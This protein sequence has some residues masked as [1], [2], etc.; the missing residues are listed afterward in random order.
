VAT[1][2][3]TDRPAT[4]ASPIPPAV[5]AID[6]IPSDV[7]SRLGLGPSLEWLLS[8]C[9]YLPLAALGFM[10]VWL[11]WSSELNGC[12]CW[13]QLLLEWFVNWLPAS[14]AHGHNVLV[15]NYQYA[16]GGINLMWNN[17]VLAL[18]AVA[19][20]LT[21]TIGVVHTFA[22]LLTVSLALSASTMFLLLRQW[23][24]WVPAA[25]FGGLVYGFSTLAIVETGSGRL[26]ASFNAIPPLVALIVIKLIRKEWS[27]T[28]GGF[29][30]GLLLT[31]QL[32]ISEET[33]AITVV[34]IGV[35]LVVLA[36][37]NRADVVT[38]SAEIIR[39]SFVTAVT[40]FALS[41]YP[42]YVEFFGANRITGSPRPRAELTRLSSDLASLV[43]PGGTQWLTFGWSNRL[44]TSFSAAG[45]VTEYVGLTLLVFLIV[46]V[47]F[48]RRHTIVRIFAIV[49]LVSFT[50]SLGP[51]ALFA[52]HNTH[53]PGPD[54]VLQHLPVLG[55][56]I[57]SHYALALWFSVAVLFAL[58]LDAARVWLSEPVDA[59]L[60]KRF[61]SRTGVLTRTEFNRRRRLNRRLAGGLAVLLGMA[62]L[63]PLVPNWPYNEQPADVPA[64]FTSGVARLVPDGSLVA[65][66]PY[67]ITS[68][69]QPLLWQAETAMRFR[70]LG[71][72]AI[73][74]DSSG[75]GTVYADESPLAYCLFNI[76]S[77]GSTYWSGEH[78][79][80]LCE[81]SWIGHW[82]RILGVT[83]VIAGDNVPHVHTAVAVISSA[84]RAHPRHVDGVWLWQCSR[85]N[86]TATCSWN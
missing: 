46:T 74:P 59:L 32:F 31:I 1:D 21:E 77:T 81:P 61:D 49:A 9:T 20:P 11:H 72:Y 71:G 16:P 53:L 85:A 83:S 15:T 41:V 47:V 5:T 3:L 54:Y 27:A 64:F 55:D 65:T 84:L 24:T 25:W 38:Q 70:I 37:A 23:T 45:E 51:F 58:G 75:N 42:M 4:R 13:D 78:P 60:T 18:G 30:I 57:P 2:R 43:T 44:S 22:I 67:A 7:D 86:G 8:L 62:A 80:S 69:A 6:E 79:I 56:G 63:V 82:I 68:S 28:K 14:I 19:S 17:S 36:L 52:G 35:T 26:E 29:L 12:N 48:L 50:I 73:A 39:A 66:Y 33:F 10:P 40:F 34:F 76:Y